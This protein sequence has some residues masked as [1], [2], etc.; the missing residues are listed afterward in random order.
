MAFRERLEGLLSGA[1]PIGNLGLG[2]LSAS[3]PSFVPQS[4]GQVLASG[5]NFASQRQMEAVRNQA[6]RDQLAEQKRRSEALQ[7]LPGLLGGAEAPS[8]QELIGL[9][10]TIAPDAVVSGLLGQMFAQ[11][12]GLTEKLSTV[13][14]RL[15]RALTDEEVFKLAGGGTTINIGD[16]LNEPIPITQLDSIRL[17]N[18]STPPI[19]TTFQQAREAGATVLSVDEQKRNQQA[20]QALGILGQLETLAVGPEGVFNQVMPGIAN[21]VASAITFGF[22]MLEQKDPRAS[23]FADLSEATVAPFIKFLGE[24]GALAQGDVDRAL[25]LLPRVFPLPDT[26]EVATEKLAALRQIIERGVRKLNAGPSIPPLP[27]GF[28]LDQ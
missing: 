26:K 18:G 11:P 1:D 2:L 24:S 22:D 28:T 16:K 17:P 8:E 13:E 10:G 15:G 4:F 21:R 14:G 7:R 3:G 25:G 9:L 19:G 20:D 23:Q 27:P 5:V 12:S 6:L